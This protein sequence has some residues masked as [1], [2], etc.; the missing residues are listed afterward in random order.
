MTTPTTTDPVTCEVHVDNN[1]IADTGEEYESGAPTVLSGLTVAWGRE[2]IVDQPQTSTCA[3]TVTQTEGTLGDI[4]D[5][6]HVGNPI[7]VYAGGI[8]HDLPEGNQ[9]QVDGSFSTP[10][11]NRVTIPA[12]AGT[13]AV[14]SVKWNNNPSVE[15]I[16][17]Q[18]A[19]AYTTNGALVPPAPF[20]DT[21]SAWDQIPY[22][23]AGDQWVISIDWWLFYYGKNPNNGNITDS[24]S[25]PMQ[26]RI[27]PIMFYG[28]SKTSSWAKLGSP[29]TL[30]YGTKAN[31]PPNKTTYK[32][33]YTIPTGATSGWLGFMI[34]PR[35]RLRW[36]TGPG[37]LID[38]TIT[39]SQLG[40]PHP[41]WSE[42]DDVGIDNF[43]LTAPPY[44][45]RL[46]LVFSGRITDLMVRADKGTGATWQVTAADA[47]ADLANDA[48]GD[49]PWLVE[50]LASRVARIQALA[51]DEFTY[52]ID[53]FPA[54]LNQSWKDVDSQAVMDLLRELAV[55]ADAVLW[56]AFHLTVG[57]YLWFEDPMLRASLGALV[58][59]STLSLVV[60]DYSGYHPAGSAVISSCD[61][62]RDTPSFD[63]DVG[64]VLTRVDA[65]WQEQTVDEGGLPAPTE[66]NVHVVNSD[67]E[68]LYGI[69]A[70]SVSTQL[71]SA[72][73]CQTIASRM[74]VRSQD[75]SWRMLNL[76]WDTSLRDMNDQDIAYA[77]RLLN[78]AVR[79]GLPVTVTELPE[80]SPS[81]VTMNAY[82][83]G[84]TYTF[85]AGRWK[86]ALNV[87][88]SESVGLSCMWNQLVPTWQWVQ[89]DP[90]ISWD[91]LWGISA[92]ATALDDRIASVETRAI[93]KTEA[94]A[95][96]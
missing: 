64:D 60:I 16:P 93:G 57:F 7:D 59:D 11:G 52:Q 73:D 94:I 77:L 38:Q 76:E 27:Q 63:S 96:A 6:L 58:W 61:V 8:T 39:W 10:I 70:A 62:V 85:D 23:V 28:P 50:T 81:G 14:K 95:S 3:F 79:N 41:T 68:A 88:P 22:A 54:S 82:L 42:F 25:L 53:P 66:R 87:S 46:V 84:G 31:V 83:E 36:A 43:V 71:V 75:L 72:T 18:T 74:L 1:V 89:F 44:R 24:G 47:T 5:L 19:T 30:P 40:T 29:I 80:W 13:T 49:N 69:R 20:S 91:A 48:I 65:T 45:Q 35:P 9:V 17:G 92:S 26:A 34:W 86:L 2:T 33:T 51:T 56:S 15:V 37:P 55:S 4:F 12:Q 67:D 21:P 90:T 78:G 32:L